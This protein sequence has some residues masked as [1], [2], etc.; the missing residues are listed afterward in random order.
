MLR[1]DEAED[2]Q[3]DAMDYVGL[4]Y[5]YFTVFNVLDSRGI[6]VIY[7]FDWT[8]NMTLEKWD[9]LSLH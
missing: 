6:I 2:E 4:G 7:S 3:V 8:I 1:R 5:P 9:I